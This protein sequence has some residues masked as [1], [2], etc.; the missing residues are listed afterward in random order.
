MKLSVVYPPAV[1]AS[2]SPYHPGVDEIDF[3]R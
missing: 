3:V 1:P 2:A